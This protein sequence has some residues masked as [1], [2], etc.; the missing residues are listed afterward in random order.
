MIQKLVYPKFKTIDQWF[1]NTAPHA[2]QIKLKCSR[3]MAP[4]S[5]KQWRG[6]HPDDCAD[7]SIDCGIAVMTSASWG[8]WEV[9]TWSYYWFCITGEKEKA[10]EAFIDGHE[11]NTVKT[12]LSELNFLTS[13]LVIDWFSVD[14]RREW[15]PNSFR[16]QQ[17]FGE[18]QS[19]QY[20][21]FIYCNTI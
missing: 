19:K 2:P 7:Y 9:A 11:E 16:H 12:R 20:P 4:V 1:Y 18:I 10:F 6:Y 5:R 8:S 13:T 15:S 3:V 17:H 14:L 21:A